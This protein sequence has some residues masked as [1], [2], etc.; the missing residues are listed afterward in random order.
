MT[1]EK[2]ILTTETK[3]PLKMT[4]TK[5]STT[6]RPSTTTMRPTTTK[7]LSS[8]SPRTTFSKM[9]QKDQQFSFQGI[10]NIKNTLAPEISRGTTVMGHSRIS[11]IKAPIG[12]KITLNEKGNKNKEMIPMDSVPANEYGQKAQQ[13]IGKIARTFGIKLRRDVPISVNFTAPQGMK[14]GQTNSNLN[15]KLQFLEIHTRDLIQRN[16]DRLWG[17]ICDLHNRQMDTVTSILSINPTLGTRLWLRKLDISAKFAGEAISVS[18]C[19]QFSPEKVFWN[20][21]IN[22]TCYKKVPVLI[23]EGNISKVFFLVSGSRSQDLD[24]FSEE[25]SCSDRPISVFKDEEGIWQTY[26]GP[27]S[28]E[29][30]PNLLPYQ[31]EKTSAIFKSE[32]IFQS[33]LNSLMASVSI[34]HGYANRINK[35][36]KIIKKQNYSVKYDQNILKTMAQI[37][38]E[39]GNLTEG[40]KTLVKAPLEFLFGDLKV[41]ITVIGGILL[42][43]L[44]IGVIIYFYPWIMPF[45]DFRRETKIRRKELKI[46]KRQE[47]DFDK[48]LDRELKEISESVKRKWE[49]MEVENGPGNVRKKGEK[50]DL[51][52]SIEPTAPPE[53]ETFIHTWVP[54]IYQIEIPDSKRKQPYVGIKLKGIE[55]RALLD[56]GASVSYCRMSVANEIGI[57]QS[58]IGDTQKIAKVA[59]GNFFQFLA[60]MEVNFELENIVIPMEIFISRNEHCPTEIILGTDFMQALSRQGYEISFDWQNEA[61]KL[62]QICGDNQNSIPMIAN[63]IFEDKANK[64]LCKDKIELEPHTDT[65]IPAEIMDKIEE[66]PIFISQ[67]TFPAIDCLI[68]GKTLCYPNNVFVRILN[69]GNSKYTIFHG[70][71]IAKWESIDK[72][73]QCETIFGM[74]IA[75]EIGEK[76]TP[77]IDIAAKW[78][79]ATPE[80]NLLEN[81]RLEESCLSE[82][83]KN[84][85]K[86]IILRNQEA[87]VSSDGNIGYFSGPVKHR[88]DLI[89][90]SKIVQQKPYRVPPGLR[91]EVHKQIHELLRQNIIRESQSAFSSP[92]VLVKKKDGKYRFA[93]DYRQLNQNTK[94]SC[95]FL[96]VIQDILDEIGGK[97]IFSSFDFQSGFFQIGIEEE[98]IERTAFATFCGVFEFLRMP[99]GLCGAPCTFQKSMEFL[100]KELGNGILC[101]LD[102]LIISSIDESSHLNDIENLLKIL[103]RYNLK[104]RLDKCRFGRSEIKYLGFLISIHGI[105]PDP[106]NVAA[107]QRFDPPKT[108]HQLRS[109]I[110]CVSYFRRFIKN[111]ATIMAPLNELTKSEESVIKRWGPDHQKAFDE[112]KRSLMMAPVLAPPK[113]D[114]EF[115]VETDASKVAVAGCLLQK[116]GDGEHPIGYVSRKLNPAEQRYTTAEM[117]ALAIVYSL[118]KFKPYIEGNKITIVRTDNSVACSLLRKRDLVGRLAKYQLSIQEYNIKIEHRSGKSNKFCDYL[119]RFP[120]ENGEQEHNCHAIEVDW[121]M[122]RAR[123]EGKNEEGIKDFELPKEFYYPSEKLKVVPLDEIREELRKDKGY[124]DIIEILEKDEGN[125]ENLDEKMIRIHENYSLIEGILYRWCEFEGNSHPVI[126]VP[127]GLRERIIREFHEDVLLGAHLGTIKTLQKIRN[128]FWWKSLIRDVKRHVNACIK[129]QQRKTHVKDNFKEPLNPIPV[130]QAPMERIHIEILGPLPITD[131]GFKYILTIVDAFSKWL[132]AIP[133][134]NQTAIIVTRTFIDHFLTKFGS[135]KFLVSDNGKQFV[136]KIFEDLA[137]IYGFKHNRTTTYRPQANGAVERMNRVIADMIFNYCNSKGDNWAEFLQSVCFAYNTSIHASTEFSPFYVLFLRNPL[138]PVDLRMQKERGNVDERE[139]NLTE[140]IENYKKE[141]MDISGRVKQAIGKAQEKQKECIDKI[142]KAKEHNFAM[143]ELVLTHIDHWNTENYHK[144][145]PK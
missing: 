11:G 92:I 60:K 16:F 5:K 51:V 76:G 30:F 45:I 83:A 139:M 136:S 107:V 123:L 3:I 110:G 90:E 37:T 119:S 27:T 6:V 70:Q 28:V 17:Q 79:E 145:R 106:K 18:K 61:I 29:N 82:P 133:M 135:P 48:E 7:M 98:H 22:G 23:S 115:I 56:T 46:R 143:G 142:R 59:N 118:G 126:V 33:D 96:P 102:D 52:F 71:N 43:I 69:V 122:L 42:I 94:K 40:V 80:T 15:V 109:F 57:Q 120:G 104:L 103:K 50:Y 66:W 14:D 131:E 68:V 132:I 128:R 117:E 62:S 34:L 72:N 74:G 81:L 138:L 101:Y 93:I 41:Y 114:R 67:G 89:D 127:F 49:V 75:P 78:P 24:E 44:L 73:A 91:D 77:E 58:K 85:L 121:D 13:I 20:H 54:K 38:I 99:M 1:T 8:T 36:D 87:F 26:E 111:F 88:I 19:Y 39:A 65:L 47:D 64:V 108:L 140:Y 125:E 25:I 124:K 97:S 4:S 144:F 53:N 113:F 130:P 63:L 55:F 134:L 84:E 12:T 21:E 2:P 10:K 86:N 112:I 116:Y 141:L 129:C 31:P 9:G 95:Y 35:N 105:R 100:R 137:K 32:T